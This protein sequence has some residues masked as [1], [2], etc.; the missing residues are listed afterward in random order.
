M[1]D[2]D[3]A[4]FRT[5]HPRAA[6]LARQQ[7]RTT[8]ALVRFRAGRYALGVEWFRAVTRWSTSTTNADQVAM[9]VMYRL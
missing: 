2:P 6:P 5:E 3:E 9:S 4:R 7:N 8:D 1:D